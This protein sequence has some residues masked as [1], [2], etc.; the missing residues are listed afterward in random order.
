MI[1][2]VKFRSLSV[3]IVKF[4]ADGAYGKVHEVRL[5]D[6][7]RAVAKVIDLNFTSSRKEKEL[8]LLKNE[9]AANH[10]FSQPQNAHPA[11]MQAYGMRW[12][13]HQQT[14]FLVMPYVPGVELFH[15]AHPELSGY[16]DDIRE[17]AT[18]LRKNGRNVD[19]SKLLKELSLAD[20]Q[21]ITVQLIAVVAHMHERKWMHRD[22]KPEN[23]LWDS[24]NKKLL[25]I[26]FG[27]AM[28]M[29]NPEVLVQG[30]MGTPNYVAPELVEKMPSFVRSLGILGTTISG[31]GHSF[32]IDVWAIGISMFFLFSEQGYTPFEKWQRQWGGELVPDDYN[33][34]V[35]IRSGT[36]TVTNEVE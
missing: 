5:G 35:H 24:E 1:M 10:Y 36:R 15:A 8:A 17:A 25:L 16:N 26:D 6:G 23:C 31:P 32:P 34:Y 29:T 12:D 4:I 21:S 2:N 11:L 19:E 33:T 3:E 30:S 7:S 14:A 22:I 27:F 9:F 18:N 13:K 28:R 20:K